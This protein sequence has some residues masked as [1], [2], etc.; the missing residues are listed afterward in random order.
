MKR[1]TVLW[2]LVILGLFGAAWLVNIYVDQQAPRLAKD[3]LANHY[4]SDVELKSLHMRLLPTPRIRGEGLALIRKD[5]DSKVPFI[6]VER[7]TASASLWN[8]LGRKRKI[9]R[10]HL[11]GLTINI[12]RD[13]DR[14]QSTAPRRRV[15]EFEIGQVESDHAKLVILP[16]EPGTEG[17]T[18]ELHSLRVEAAGTASAMRFQCRLRNAVPPG[19]IDTKGTFGPWNF[20]DTGKTP[21]SGDY[22]FHNADLSV[23]KGISGMLSSLGRFH[24]TLDRIGVEGTTDTP[25][26]MVEASGHKIPLKTEF[27]AVVDGTN[28][29][30]ELKSVVARFLDSTVS[31]KGGVYGKKG[32]KGRDVRLEVST[33]KARVEDMLL[34]AVKSEPAMR[35][36]LIFKANLEIPP[37]ER[38]FRDRMKVTGQATVENAFLTKQETK[39][40]LASLS[41]RAKGEPQEVSDEEVPAIIDANFRLENAVLRI[42]GLNFQVPGATA[43]LQGTYTLETQRLDFNGM[44]ALKAKPSE[45]ATGW[46]SFLLKM[47]DPI[48]KGKKAG[49]VLPVT[50]TGTRSEPKFRLKLGDLQKA[51]HQASGVEPD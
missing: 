39:E 5:G 26:F 7:F 40:K 16:R 21:V 43:K 37:G 20:D 12:A 38:R 23:F 41:R 2:A 33:D 17:K 49:T 46:K 3:M 35:G 27:S 51:K 10:V 6:A 36:E 15:P 45:M 32:V 8:M 28:G 9:N 25:D 42:S 22:A 14:N 47:A 34:M 4:R 24:G 50:V 19:E 48:F 11:E 31:A 30:T 13:A 18:F 29:N 44:A 1:R